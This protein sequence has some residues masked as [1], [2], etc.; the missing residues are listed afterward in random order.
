MQTTIKHSET[1]INHNEIILLNTGTYLLI[2]YTH[3]VYNL[4]FGIDM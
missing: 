2:A 3:I 4:Y 1:L